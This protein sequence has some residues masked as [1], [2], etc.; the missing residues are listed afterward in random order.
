MAKKQKVRRD[1]SEFAGQLRTQI[2]FLRSSCASYDDGETDEALR[3][4]VHIRVL[5]HDTPRSTS[6][7]THMGVKK[8]WTW[9]HS[10]PATPLPVG[11]IGNM[12]AAS[13]Q[14]TDMLG[15]PRITHVALCGDLPGLAATDSN[16]PPESRPIK[17]GFD[18]WWTDV[19]IR[20]AI[21]EEFSRRDLVLALANQEG[22]AHVDSLVEKRIVDLSRNNSLAAYAF[23]GTQVIPFGNNPLKEAVRQIAWEVDETVSRCV[24]ELWPPFERTI[25]TSQQRAERKARSDGR[26]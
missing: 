22:G 4:A 15:R 13:Q 3:L 1:E 9:R 23:T 2:K 5:V 16:V 17:I 11:Q 8:R 6:L 12:L 20:D 19:V 25:W 24:P 26:S 10:Q 21:G 14:E 7:L 18:S